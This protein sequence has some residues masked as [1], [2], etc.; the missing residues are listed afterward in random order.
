MNDR[1]LKM[2]FNVVE[3]TN[4]LHSPH[5]V[6][7]PRQLNHCFARTNTFWRTHLAGRFKQKA[8]T[9]AGAF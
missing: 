4:A 9:K 6:M 7:A 2:H 3:N 1:S 8:P 5:D